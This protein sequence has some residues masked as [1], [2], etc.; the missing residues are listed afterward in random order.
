MLSSNYIYMY[1]QICTLL[2]EG[3]CW[4]VWTQTFEFVHSL[5]GDFSQVARFCMK[6]IESSYPHMVSITKYWAPVL[7]IYSAN[8]WYQ[9]LIKT[10]KMV[11]FT[12][13][14]ECF[15]FGCDGLPARGWGLP[16][17]TQAGS[18]SSVILSSSWREEWSWELCNIG[19][20]L[21]LSNILVFWSSTCQRNSANKVH[22]QLPAIL[23]FLLEGIMKFSWLRFDLFCIMPWLPSYLLNELF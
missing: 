7:V 1:K 13:I 21:I 18:G 8:M 2:I 15:P 22:V 14:Q 5:G 10:N 20:F 23:N 3:E 12:G 16:S 4:G 17:L 6:S 19:R 9:I 11:Q